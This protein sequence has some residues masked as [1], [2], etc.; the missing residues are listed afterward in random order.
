MKNALSELGEKVRKEQFCTY[1][2]YVYL[3]LFSQ[4]SP[5]PIPAYG[6]AVS[7]HHHFLT[8]TPVGVSTPVF[9]MIMIQV[10]GGLICYFRS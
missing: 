8:C 10:R 6:Q 7:C 5:G 9:V 2:V 1:T 4:P 3:P